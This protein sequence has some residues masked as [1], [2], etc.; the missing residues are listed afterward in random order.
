M[1]GNFF[2]GQFFGGGFFGAATTSSAPTP[3]L[4]KKRRGRIEHPVEALKRLRI[5]ETII[6]EPTP[7]LEDDDDILIMALSRVLH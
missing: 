4:R 7:P 1:S 6:I 5:E 3:A 2:D